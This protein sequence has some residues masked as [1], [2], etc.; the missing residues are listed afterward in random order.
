VVR[1]NLFATKGFERDV[2]RKTTGWVLSHIQD[3]E[4][5]SPREVH[6]VAEVVIPASVGTRSDTIRRAE[7]RF[8][9][10]KV[11]RPQMKVGL[12]LLVFVLGF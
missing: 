6:R 5:M 10:S 7:Q 3:P 2:G 12:V 8:K 4:E 11:M 9:T 1:F